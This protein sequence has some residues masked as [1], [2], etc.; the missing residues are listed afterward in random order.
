LEFCQFFFPLLAFLLVHIKGQV[1][2]S[3]KV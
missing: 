3:G 2:W 1:C